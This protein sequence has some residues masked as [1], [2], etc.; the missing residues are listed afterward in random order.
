MRRLWRSLRGHTQAL[1]KV[2][3]GFTAIAASDD[4][5]HDTWIM[6][7]GVGAAVLPVLCTRKLQDWAWG[8]QK[9]SRA[10]WSGS[11]SN[12]GRT[13]IDGLILVFLGYLRLV[14]V[15]TPYP[16]AL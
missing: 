11:G 2:E 12:T 8:G 9:N 16:Q 3:G 14:N 1:I 5:Q 7:L 10:V 15:P 4:T 13:G 6:R